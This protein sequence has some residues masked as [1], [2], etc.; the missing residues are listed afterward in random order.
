M[1]CTVRRKATR[2][3]IVFFVVSV[4]SGLRPCR[5]IYTPVQPGQDLCS[6]SVFHFL[7]NAQQMALFSASAPLTRT[8]MY[9]VVR[10]QGS[11]QS[12]DQAR[13]I[14]VSSSNR[15]IHSFVR[16][17]AK[18]REIRPRCFSKC[19]KVSLFGGSK[20]SFKVNIASSQNAST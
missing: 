20:N 2:I 1:T 10:T 3:E 5:A 17:R 16:S 19:L 14:F 12:L 9:A 4:N 18:E 6:S 15:M 11:R 13:Q 7:S 8:G